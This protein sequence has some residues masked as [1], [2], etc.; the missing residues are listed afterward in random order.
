MKLFFT[1]LS[2]ALVLSGSAQSVL[3][4]GEWHKVEVTETGIYKLDQTFL[5]DKLGIP[6]D[7]DPAGIKVYGVRG[8]M[9]PQSN[10]IT[11]PS[12]P[13]ELA[14][15]MSGDNDAVLD[16][17]E[18]FLFYA[19]GPDN[20]YFDS[21]NLPVHEN[22]LYAESTYY[23]VTY[24]PEDGKRIK[25]I[26]AKE[27][28]GKLIP[29]F[30]DYITHEVDIHNTLK[31]GR[32]WL[33]EDFRR[34]RDKQRN[35][36]YDITGSTGPV[37]AYISLA[38]N[39]ELEI[40]FDISINNTP[41]GQVPIDQIR[42]VVYDDKVKYAEAAFDYIMTGNTLD[43]NIS[44]NG[45]SN[46]DSSIGYLDFFI[47]AV[48]RSLDLSLDNEF[49]VR[50][51]EEELRAFKVVG[52]TSQSQI[53]NV[54]NP[55]DVHQL[56]A[57]QNGNE[58]TFSNNP[59]QTTLVMLDGQ[60]FPVPS[61]IGTMDNQNIKSL[62]A[63]EGIIITHP[64]FLSQAIRLAN[65]HRNHSG[66]EVG[67]VTPQQIYN[68]FSAGRQDISALRDF[69]RYCYL[70]GGN[71]KYATLFGD[72]SYDYKDRALPNTNYVPVYESVESS[73]N[74]Y[75]H[76]SD[77][78]FGF[79]EENE[80]DWFE[81]VRKENS[82]AY[83]IPFVD[84]T[85]E[86]GVGRLPV[87]TLKEATDVVDKIIRY[88]TAPQAFG[89]W[90][91]QLAYF[92]DDGDN[93]VHMEHAES[94]FKIVDTTALQYG[95]KKL[96]LDIYEQSDPIYA[97]EAIQNT[98]KDGVFMFNYM[99]HGNV[100]QLTRE[101]V[102]TQTEIGTFTNRHKLPLFI[103]A[104]C[105]FGK[106]DNPTVVSGAERL[107]LSANGGAI[108]LLTTTRPVYAHTNFP[109]NQAL[110]ENLFKKI[111]GKHPRLGDVIR[112]TKNQSLNGP[113][114]RNFS[115][116]GDPMLT[117][118]YPEYEISFDQLENDQDTLSALETYTLSGKV[119][120]NG[121][122]VSGFNGKGIVTLLDIP[123]TKVT[124]G[125]END[126]FTYEDQSNAL[127]RGEVTIEDGIFSGTFILPK[128]I[129]YK[130]LPGKM[131]MYAWNENEAIDASGASRNFVLGGTAPEITQDRMSPEVALYINDL[132]FKQGSTVGTS[133]LL[134]AKISDAS[135]VNI[136]NNGFLQGVT[137]RL[138]D[139][140]SIDLS[141]FYTAE[142]DNFR[143]GTVMFPLQNLEAGRYTATIKVHDAHNNPTEES[144]EFK[145][146]SQPV[147]RL[148]NV[149]NYPNPVS[150]S[151]STTF[152]FEH[153]REDEKLDVIL[154]LYNMEGQ[155]V[156]EIDYEVDSSP[157]LVDYLTINAANDS[158]APLDNGIYL[159]RL[160][161]TSSLDG[162]T[163]EVVKRL[164]IIN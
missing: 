143:K 85:M 157:R 63:S 51:P 73:H 130:Y 97:L 72:G 38:A 49:V 84:H 96:Y 40:T 21:L 86:I 155:V 12:D 146:S 147:L 95:A 50:L 99:G 144:V 163:N 156:R 46:V 54:S 67:V 22:N 57:T 35:F 75:S 138:N 150:S 28:K 100:S 69:L 152:R 103:T 16:A 114:N 45:A 133:S 71:L 58:V 98:I 162:A 6:A 36:Q 136:S 127:F 159:Y 31:S 33:G 61:Y 3:S 65:F 83:R 164:I 128:N 153:D 125:Q 76:S 41:M 123:Q 90:R 62:V 160:Q 92:S 43:L 70:N 91:N 129:S 79:M 124:K 20:F 161:V 118:N 37:T 93:E 78:F 104:T 117:L 81:G 158:G 5:Q 19:E 68:E 48:Q 113:I 14:I 140:E 87:K 101:K 108:A 27:A 119:L 115:L 88:R 15:F 131:T 94:F 56:V 59:G 132:D 102:I 112:L 116:L 7:T 32:R 109:L 8:G 110:H 47:L 149:S 29:E 53:W 145:V 4:S 137:L 135:G 107:L 55:F 82:S 74:I 34:T 66:I 17:D 106:Y 2:L 154:S 13:E 60:D 42:N 52:V 141:E 139:G 64:D 23:F 39:S 24:G 120:E 30:T 126:P 111:D 134:I 11:R 1:T 25:A 122:L 142:R 148:Y 105:E 121:S 9:L 44:F 10:A 26:D 151:G 77:D 18:Y 80:G 89:K